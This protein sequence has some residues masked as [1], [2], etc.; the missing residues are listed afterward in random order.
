MTADAVGGVWRYAIDLAAGLSTHEVQTI[1]AVVGPAP[2]AGQRAEAQA[3]AGLEL[4]ETG[5]PLDWT[6]ADEAAVAEA[7]ATLAAMSRAALPSVVHLNTPAFAAVAEF[8]APVVGVAHSC[9][10]TWWAA[11][12]SGSLP[13]D[14]AWRADLAGRGYRACDRVLAPTRA[15][16]EATAG[17][18]G[19]NATPT[20]VPNGRRPVP[21]APS[22]EAPALF[23]FL[24]GRLWDDGKN[25]AVVDAAAEGLS[26]PVY[27]AGPVQGANGE[28]R[29][30][31]R[32]R[33]LGTLGEAELAAWLAAGP[34]FVSP[35]LYE[36]FGLAVLE[37]AQAGCALVLSDIPTFRE[38]WDGAALFVDPRSPSDIRS[39]IEALAADPARR[40]QLGDAAQKQARRYG[41]QAMTVG[42]LGAY[43]A[44][45]PT[46]FAPE[47]AA[48]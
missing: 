9:V 24:A 41:P 33:S 20:V 32:L 45:A 42:V 22:A 26:I 19:L 7:G 23:A 8:G 47:E 30:F 36:P 21:A 5:L 10:A 25:V 18:Y 3:I 31:E 16:A 14:V 48:A 35:A 13:A 37:A 12:R 17:A 28:L 43:A 11:V 44:V 15:F 2:D 6:A 4:V 29:Q 38:L 46:V 1:L 40:S 27:V 34:I 39:A